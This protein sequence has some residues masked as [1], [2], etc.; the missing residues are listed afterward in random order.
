V[1]TPQPVN[2]S[3]LLGNGDGTFASPFYLSTPSYICSITPHT[4][5]IPNNCGTY[6]LSSLAADLNGDG[7]PDLVTVGMQPV[8][9]PAS[10]VYSTVS[11]LSAFINDSPGDGFLTTGISSTGGTGTTNGFPQ[12]ATSAVEAIEIPT[13]PGFALG[14]NS[15]V[16]AYGIN[17][18]PATAAAAG[19]P[20]P[21]TLG[22]IRLH[23]GSSLAQ[24]LYVSPTQINYLSPAGPYLGSFGSAFGTLYANPPIGIEIV[25]TPFIQKGLV[26][27]M[28]PNE[29]GLFV[30]DSSGVAAATAVR[31]AADGTQTPVPVFNCSTNPCTAVP[32]DLSGDPVYLS[33]YGTGF[34]YGLGEGLTVAVSCGGNTT[35]YAGAQGVTPGLDQIN[36]LLAKRS[37]GTESV[38]CQIILSELSIPNTINVTS[39]PVQIA[40]K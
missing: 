33:L 17:L 20:F 22:G 2:M 12:G 29:P 18:A 8:S 28:V 34:D 1:I 6:S 5:L 30:V 9:P 19:P 27:P 31:V 32:I 21:T 37:S 4:Q 35:I 10:M 3:V 26:L 23:L 16:S 24:L 15:L 40:I 25:G 7:V 11:L 13:G 39:N 14:Q 36:V 38:S